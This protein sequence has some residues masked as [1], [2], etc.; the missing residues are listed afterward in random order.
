MTCGIE[1]WIAGS[2]HSCIFSPVTS[3]IGEGLFGLMVGAGIYLAYYLAGGGSAVTPTVVIIL[4]ATMLF[5][6]LPAAYVGIAWSI[7]VVGAAATVLQVLQKYML[8]PATQ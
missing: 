7:L 6:L 5:P 2:W 1:E 8:S 4:L 3:L